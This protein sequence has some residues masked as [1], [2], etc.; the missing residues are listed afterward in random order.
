FSFKVMCTSCRART[1][2]L[3]GITARCPSLETWDPGRESRAK[4]IRRAPGGP[5]RGSRDLR[6]RLGDRAELVPPAPLRCA[7]PASRAPLGEGP[8]HLR[9][10]PHPRALTP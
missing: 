4:D 2:S 5:R 8:A 7:R 3:I 9:R 10:A 1:G 6:V